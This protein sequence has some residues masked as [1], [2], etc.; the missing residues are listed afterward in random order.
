MACA[1]PPVG[2]L[3]SRAVSVGA[4]L[5][6][7]FANF[8]RRGSLNR[9]SEL[10]HEA[11]RQSA[12]HAEV[13]VTPLAHLIA[14]YYWHPDSIIRWIGHHEKSKQGQVEMVLRP[15]DTFQPLLTPFA[16][17]LAKDATSVEQKSLLSSCLLVL[18]FHPRNESWRRGISV[19][20]QVSVVVYIVRAEPTSKEIVGQT[21]SEGPSELLWNSATRLFFNDCSMYAIRIQEH[22]HRRQ[23]ERNRTFHICLEAT[24]RGGF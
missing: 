3:D 11:V 13:K 2:P 8:R 12:A 21:E 9:A 23:H 22:A 4:A 16:G 17:C 1:A 19:G 14:E 7:E 18:D 6:R 24:D 5:A 20:G 15:L 10:I